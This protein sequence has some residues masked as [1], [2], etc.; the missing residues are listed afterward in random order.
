MKYNTTLNNEY[1]GGRNHD[2]FVKSYPVFH[3]S[4]MY[5]VKCPYL[6][7]SEV[8]KKSMSMAAIFYPWKKNSI[9][10]LLKNMAYTISQAT[11]EEC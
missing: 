3:M 10:K 4:N 2:H 7:H 8:K 6:L 9:S 5:Y 11:A 1:F